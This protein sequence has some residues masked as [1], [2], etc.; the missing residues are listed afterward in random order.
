MDQPA[1]QQ[2]NNLRVQ[3]DQTTT[4]YKTLPLLTSGR[5]SVQG[6]LQTAELYKDEQYQNVFH[7]SFGRKVTCSTANSVFTLGAE[8][9][10]KAAFEMSLFEIEETQD[11]LEII[12][13][14]PSLAPFLEEIAARLPSFFP[15]K[16]RLSPV[17]DYDD[18][19]LLMLF[20]E[21]LTT[22]DRFDEDFETLQ[23]FKEEWWLEN[24]YRGES[25][26]GIVLSN[27]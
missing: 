3:E 7:Y 1:V 15:R 8:S 20:I 19:G 24:S 11:V 26:L 23:R 13:E 4:K 27:A 21:I 9:T 5:V 14:L 6:Q 12:S 2:V 16:A 18:G 25:R 17:T 10:K 22:E